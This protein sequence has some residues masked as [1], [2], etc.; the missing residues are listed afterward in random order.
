[1][2]EANEMHNNQERKTVCISKMLC[3]FRTRYREKHAK[4]V[5]TKRVVLR[6]VPGPM[7]DKT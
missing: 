7:N 4:Y 6:G 3:I 5:L 2:N 1:M